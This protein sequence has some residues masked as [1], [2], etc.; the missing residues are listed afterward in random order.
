MGGHDRCCVAGCDNDKRHPTK[1]CKRSH[2][3]ELIFHAFPKDE[4]RKEHWISQVSKGLVN[5]KLWGKQVRICSNH[6]VDG[7][8]T[9]ENSFPTLFLCER[10]LND[11]SPKKRARVERA[12]RIES[13]TK[14]NQSSDLSQEK[15][16]QISLNK[17]L[18]ISYL[19]RESNVR[20]FSGL[21][22]SQTFYMLFDYIVSKAQHLQ[23]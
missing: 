1:L 11:H 12:P 7:K 20:C 4:K 5:F 3:T 19:G 16:T 21:P 17:G 15:A 9:T 6:F 18:E 22:N 10:D 8:P 23:Y 2:V 13:S 14:A